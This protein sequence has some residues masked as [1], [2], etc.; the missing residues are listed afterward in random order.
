MTGFCKHI[1]RV[2]DCR[3]MRDPALGLTF[4]EAY[5]TT[6]RFPSHSHAYYVVGM[7]AKGN[8]G[9]THRGRR[10]EA[11]AGGMVAFG[12]E[13]E[14]T[15]EADTG[16][17]FVWRAIYPTREQMREAAE[18]LCGSRAPVSFSEVRIDDVVLLRYFN[19]LHWALRKKAPQM[20]RE[21]LLVRFF[22]RLITR[23]ASQGLRMEPGHGRR[24]T[25][26]KARAFL[27]ANL[28][29]PVTLEQV[30]RHVGTDR[31][32]LTRDFNRE[33]GLAPHAYLDCLRVR[34]A[35]RLLAKGMP[36]GGSG[37]GCWV[38]GP[39]PSDKAF[40]TPDRRD[41]GALSALIAWLHARPHTSAP[42]A[43]MGFGRFRHGKATLISRLHKS[44]HPKFEK[45]F[46]RNIG[47]LRSINELAF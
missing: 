21:A 44:T 24:R 4:C 19:V 17:G 36:P 23:H 41:S 20:T 11:P 2:N 10:Y 32:R 38:R 43:R 39:E 27:E 37:P 7:I 5:F 12:P 47:I 15:C 14:H 26:Q 34:E 3:I 25:V 6:H 13:E 8:H 29:R 16:E 18:S 33:L 42:L 46:C 35:Q 9:F 31:Y 30:A 22:T 40:Q 28:S 1:S 45:V